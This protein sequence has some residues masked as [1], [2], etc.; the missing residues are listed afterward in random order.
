MLRQR[1]KVGPKG[2]T[3]IPKAVRDKLGIRPGDEVE[4]REERGRVIVEPVRRGDPLKELLSAVQH[5]KPAPRRINWNDEYRTQF[6]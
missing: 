4:V 1:T 2:Q 6:G 5:K 3:V